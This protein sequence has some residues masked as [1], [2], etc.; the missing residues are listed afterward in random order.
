MTFNNEEDGVQ[1]IFE[2]RLIEWCENR[3]SNDDYGIFETDETILR[4]LS[5][6]EVYKD[7]YIIF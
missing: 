5:E 7:L 3:S 6:R 1:Q 4:S 2:V